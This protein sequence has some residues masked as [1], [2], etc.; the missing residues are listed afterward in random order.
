M[1]N[2]TPFRPMRRFKQQMTDEACIALLQ[3]ASTVQQI[4]DRSAVI[5][6]DFG[7]VLNCKLTLQNHYY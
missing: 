4:Q 6:E 5:N 3:K 1:D 7:E 2:E